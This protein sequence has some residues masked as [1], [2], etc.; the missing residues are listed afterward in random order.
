MA[1]TKDKLLEESA[2]HKTFTRGKIAAEMSED[3]A[4]KVESKPAALHEAPPPAGNTRRPR[5]PA[6]PLQV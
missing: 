6:L 1:S 5:P 2:A 3:C 4:R